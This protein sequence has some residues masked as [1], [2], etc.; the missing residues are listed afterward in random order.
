MRILQEKN[1]LNC[2]IILLDQN[3]MLWRMLVKENTLSVSQNPHEKD[4]E[5]RQ[6]IILL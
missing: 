5:Y 1:D 3:T 2:K 6:N 4:L